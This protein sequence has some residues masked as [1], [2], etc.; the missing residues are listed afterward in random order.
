MSS[1]RNYPIPGFDMLGEVVSKYTSPG[2]AGIPFRVGSMQ[3][4]LTMQAQQ[5]GPD[6]ASHTLNTWSRLMDIPTEMIMY[7]VVV[8]VRFNQPRSIC[9]GGPKIDAGAFPAM[10]LVHPNEFWAEVSAACGS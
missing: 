4:Y 9:K 8:L 6:A 1:D 10:D 2:A 5:H 7:D 3:L